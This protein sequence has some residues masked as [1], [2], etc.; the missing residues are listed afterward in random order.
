MSWS[1]F[2]AHKRIRHQVSH[3]PLL[4]SSASPHFQSTTTRSTT[5]TAR[6]SPRRHCTPYPLPQEPLQPLAEQLPHEPLQANP[7]RSENNAEESLSDPEY[8]SAGNMRIN[9]PTGYEP[10]EFTTEEIATIPMMSPEEDVYQLYD[11]QREFGEQDQQAP[12]FEEMKGIW[13]NSSTKLTR[14]RGTPGCTSTSL[15]K[16]LRTLISKMESCKSC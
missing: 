14:P 6:S 16:A 9:T 7:I 2:C 1:I 3:V 13:T 10:K 5:W 4:V 12:V 8:E 15:R 11:V